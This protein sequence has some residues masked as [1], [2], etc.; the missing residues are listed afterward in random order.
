MNMKINIV[1]LK[2][3]AFI[4]EC[5][6][7]H[8]AGYDLRACIEHDIV[9]KPGKR[10]LVGLGIAMQIPNGYFGMICPRSGLAAKHGI[11]VLNSPGIIDSDYRGELKSLM[12]NLSD[13]DFTVTHGM[14]IVQLIITPYQKINWQEAASLEETVR[15]AGGYGSTGL[16]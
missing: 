1:K 5:G 2:E 4:P 7:E 6:T 10:A 3:T 11:T 14:K 13:E 16:L 9:I 15:G 8:S 12:I